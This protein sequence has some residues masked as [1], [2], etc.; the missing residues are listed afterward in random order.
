MF[1]GTAA[2]TGCDFCRS[3]N[4]E[5]ED[6]KQKGEGRD[7]ELW[8]PKCKQRFMARS[9]FNKSDRQLIAEGSDKVAAA[10]SDGYEFDTSITDDQRE[11]LEDQGAK[12][13]PKRSK[14]R[15]AG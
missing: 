6:F 5:L 8:C 15:K 3:P 2:W 1:G 14:R 7:L 11:W 10:I 9:S 12:F 4:R 13:Q